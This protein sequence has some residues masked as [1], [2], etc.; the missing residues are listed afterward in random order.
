MPRTA[1]EKDDYGIYYINQQGIKGRTLFNDDIDR[2]KFLSILTTSKEKNNFKLYAYCLTN[3][4]EYHLLINANGSDISKIM[5]EINIGYAM[6]VNYSS[7][8]YKDRYKSVLIIDKEN[9]LSILSKIHELSKKIDS[10]YNSYCFYNKDN[11]STTELLDKEDLELLTDDGCF[12]LNTDC[13]NCIKTLDKGIA[14]FNEIAQSKNLTTE[15]LLSNKSIRNDLIRQ[16]RRNSTLSL[17][18]LGNIFGGLSESTICKI[19]NNN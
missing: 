11:L 13:K 17:R 10:I 18:E 8:I 16:F 2:D 19:L 6:Y 5:K 4:N 15:Q 9:L 1:R 12:V 7:Y 14:K 3:P